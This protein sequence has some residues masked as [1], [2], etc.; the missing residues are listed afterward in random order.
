VRNEMKLS[1]YVHSSLLILSGI[2]VSLFASP[3]VADPLPSWKEG[4]NKSAIVTFVGVVTDVRSEDYVPPEE[5]I[6]VFDN[7]GTLW[8]EKP[9]YFQL[10]F[11]LDRV[12]AMAPAH[13]EWRTAQP[14]KAAV[15]GDLDAV[16]A[17]GEKGMVQIVMATHSGMTIEEFRNAAADWIANGRHPRFNKP[18]A[19]LVYQPMLELLSYL[20]ANGFKTFI[21]SGGGIELIRAFS[22][23]VYGIPPEQ[24]VGSVLK[25]KYEVRD[26]KPVIVREPEIDFVN[27]KEGKPVGIQTHIGRR[28]IAAFGN[29]DGDFQM[30][31]W[32]TSG[33]GRRLGVLIHHTDAEREWAYD[34]EAHLGRLDRGL[35]EAEARGWIVVDMKNDWAKVFPFDECP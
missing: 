20:R 28:P 23:D 13:P 19:E 34:R 14:F 5:R 1:A 31:E 9:A 30:L 29:S 12:R 11:A 3:A 18:Y 10:F 32:T 17:S 22:E 33:K 6:A 16:L 27:D 7:D 15:E 24:V 26:A 4:A 35:D 2:L 21:V 8:P 25:A